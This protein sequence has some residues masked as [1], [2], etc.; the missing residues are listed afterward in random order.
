MWVILDCIRSY[1]DK[2]SLKIIAS[3]HTH[4]TVTRHSFTA[5]FNGLV[6]AITDERAHVSM[7]STSLIFYSFTTVQD[8]RSEIITHSF[9][10]AC[11]ISR[12]LVCNKKCAYSI[13][14][15]SMKDVGAYHFPLLPFIFRNTFLFV[16]LK[17]KNNTYILVSCWEYL[18]LD[19]FSSKVKPLI[20][21]SNF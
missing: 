11:V 18:H 4:T 8:R 3:S 14:H 21:Y 16:F 7:Y 2:I 12:L 9:A 1:I 19:C 6:I 10:C 13:H 15:Y 17:K 5:T 20:D